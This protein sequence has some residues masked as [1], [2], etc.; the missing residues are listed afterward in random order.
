MSTPALNPLVDKIRTAHPGA[1]DDMDDAQLTKAVLKKYPQYSDLA[2]QPLST[3]PGA[4]S[5]M[6]AMQKQSSIGTRLEGGPDDAPLMGGKVPR[7]IQQAPNWL[8][9]TIAGAT[10]AGV[11]IPALAEIPGARKIAGRAI[12]A[13]PTIAASEAI[14]YAR[15]SLPL[16]KYIP[17]GA[18]LLPYFLGD[19]EK[20]G[21]NEK[22]ER[23]PSP[24]VYRE[25]YRAPRAYYGGKSPEP[26]PVRRGLA[27]PGKIA[28]PLEGE[29]LP[30]EPEG[31]GPT[32]P[33][34]ETIPL[35]QLPESASV[36]RDLPY[37]RGPGEVAP[38]YIGAPDERVLANKGGVIATPQRSRGLSLPSASPSER[39]DIAKP[40]IARKNVG[41]AIDSALG[42]RPIRP[43]VPVR[44]Q[45][46]ET[47]A[48][49]DLAPGH[50]PV[51][52]SVLKS[53]SYSPEKKEL[54]FVTKGDPRKVYVYG[55]VS[56]DQAEAFKQSQSKGKAWA[57]FKKQGSPLVATI[58]N[59]VRKPVIPVIADEDLNPA[60]SSGPKVR[61]ARPSR[62]KTD[63]SK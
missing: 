28:E 59:G 6:P 55:D 7:S 40:A 30:E 17:P 61:I 41:K 39:T 20:D 33:R 4:P 26:I 29:Y 54:E 62:Q 23:L 2:A 25:G 32:I 63:E 60:G 22:P 42:V 18:E 45:F 31:S 37:R 56:P 48:G 49:E 5:S 50:T 11:A 57:Q 52:S 19:K 13:V 44:D 10:A 51:E 53:Y 1:Y 24:D 14:N 38:D 47:P 43:G 27:L 9:E 46:L 35:K 8:G 3:A 12:K 58:V 34:A 21:A 36:S 15:Q 16:G